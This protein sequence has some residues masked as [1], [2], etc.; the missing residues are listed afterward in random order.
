MNGQTIITDGMLEGVKKAGYFIFDKF[1]DVLG[2]L[3]LLILMFFLNVAEW[4]FLF[5]IGLVVL[6]F[7]AG[8]IGWLLC[9]FLSMLGHA[10]LGH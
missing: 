4:I 10:Y 7:G 1:T 9:G 6:F 2:V 5:V 8:F 3:Y